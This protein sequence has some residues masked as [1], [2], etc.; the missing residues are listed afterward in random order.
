MA[1]SSASLLLPSLVLY[2]YSRLKKYRH[3]SRSKKLIKVNQFPY[4]KS[5]KTTSKG[6][7]LV[8]LLTVTN[9]TNFSSLSIADI[10]HVSVCSVT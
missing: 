1:S 8:Y 6:V 2:T 7:V 10:K 5:I 3:G 4:S 9:F